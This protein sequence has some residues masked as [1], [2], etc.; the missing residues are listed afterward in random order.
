MLS[1]RICLIFALFIFFGC[2]SSTKQTDQFLLSK[3]FLPLEFEIKNV[4]FINQQVAHCGPAT[5]TMAMNWAGKMVTVEEITN[6][7]Y[8]PGMKG[9]FQSDLIGASRRQGLIAIPVIGLS[10]ML[11]EV[12][13]GHP[14]IVFENLS[15]SWFP[16]WHYAIVFGYNLNDEY[17]LMHSGPEAF[18]KWDMRKFERSWKLGDY[19]G[20][21]V[22]PPSELSATA[23]ELSH[24]VASTG[25]DQVGKF[26]E[27]SV[28]YQTILKRWPKSLGALIGMGNWEFS[29]KKYK[30]AVQYLKLATEAHPKADAAWHNLAIAEKYLRAQK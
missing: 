14:V 20:L 10:N 2:A 22:L 3:N 25:L 24:L 29:N 30:A 12:S 6:Q 27:A 1:V 19:W 9:S 15:V 21:V 28:A 16:Q 7:V 8:T 23:D 13:A 11:Q 26:Y 5:L 4:P 17:V 18:K